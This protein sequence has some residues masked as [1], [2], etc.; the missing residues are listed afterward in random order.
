[1]I[2]IIIRGL[3]PPEWEVFRDFR[4]NAL[5]DTPGVFST[6]YDTAAAWSPENWQATIKGADHQ[7]FGL[8]DAKQLIGITAVFTD[9]DDPAGQTALLAMSFILPSYRRRGLSDMFYDAR[10]AWVRARPQFRRVRVSH[11][12]SNEVS[13][14]A[15]QRHGFVQ[16]KVAPLIWPGGETEDEI[17]YELEIP[18]KV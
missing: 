12:K 10:L 6:A 16:T 14:R 5:R 8:F 3:E 18:P 2:G 4:L 17:I 9:R 13:R 7:V 15:N 1:M 11:R